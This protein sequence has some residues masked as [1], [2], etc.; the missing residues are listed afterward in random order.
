M[1]IVRFEV[2]PTP[3]A[4]EF[5][6]CTGAYANVWID[7]ETEHGARS[8]ATREVID[9]GW[10]ITATEA[11][12]PVERSDYDH[13]GTGLRYYEQALQDGIALVFHTWRAETLH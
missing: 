2:E 8:V 5:G 4:S 13:D 3:K 10:R 6:R 1:Y 12:H 7:V 9:A 11:I